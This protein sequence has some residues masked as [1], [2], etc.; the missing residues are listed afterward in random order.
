MGSFASIA[1]AE[2]ALTR[3]FAGHVFEIAALLRVSRIIYNF[4]VWVVETEGTGLPT[5]HAVI[6][7]V[8]DAR[9]RNGNFRCKDG[10]AKS[11]IPL[12]RDRYGDAQRFEKPPFWR[13]SAKKLN[14]VRSL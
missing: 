9:V 10:S 8:S 3:K 12:L 11:A 5:P 13:V 4:R 1:G 7:P 14:G 2:T 6:E